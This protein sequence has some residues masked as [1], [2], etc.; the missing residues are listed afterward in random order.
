ME[1]EPS[2]VDFRQPNLTKDRKMFGHNN[3][4]N[5]DRYMSRSQRAASNTRRSNSSF[6]NKRVGF[7]SVGIF[8][9]AFIVIGFA[10]ISNANVESH[11][12]CVVSDKDRTTNSEGQSDMRVY[13]DNCGVFS[14]R[15]SI[16][17]M[18]FDS[19]D[20]F[21]KIKVGET[22]DFETRG[23]R[24]GMFSQFPNITQVTAT[25]K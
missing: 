20:T 19:A 25:N 9:V 17:I 4:S 3:T 7:I 15:D 5:E 12:A 14:V 1:F 8:L 2:R 6:M 22:Y 11:S 18:R 24:I 16:F 21:S 23:F 13:T 10:A